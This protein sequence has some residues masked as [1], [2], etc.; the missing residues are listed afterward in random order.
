MGNL[1][2]KKLACSLES[3]LQTDI[4]ENKLYG[5]A[6]YVHQI[7]QESCRVTM[8]ISDPFNGTP[9]SESTVFRIA[10]MTKP[11]TAVDASDGTRKITVG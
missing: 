4:S 11:I 2:M 6:L 3:R 1:D 5:A 7:G 9:V 8:G 10:S